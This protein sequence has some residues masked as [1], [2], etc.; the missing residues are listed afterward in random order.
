MLTF[1]TE[2]LPSK[3]EIGNDKS[4]MERMKKYS[5][6]GIRFGVFIYKSTQYVS[7]F[8]VFS[9]ITFL[10][11]SAFCIIWNLKLISEVNFCCTTTHIDLANTDL[12]YNI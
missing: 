12:E 8:S 9:S 3:E 10:A 2:I 6:F 4:C 5:L 1:E 7:K 11:I